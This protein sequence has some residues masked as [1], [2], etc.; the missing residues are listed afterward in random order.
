[1][2]NWMMGSRGSIVLSLYTQVGEPS[3]R[4]RAAARAGAASLDGAARRGSRV[5]GEAACA[6][7]S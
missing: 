2:M 1:M 7:F 6:R 3:R 4:R 5:T